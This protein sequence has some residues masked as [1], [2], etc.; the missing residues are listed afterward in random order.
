M[1]GY[2]DVFRIRLVRRCPAIIRV[3]GR[4]FHT[5]T[6]K[7]EKPFDYGFASC[8]DAVAKALLNDIQG[9]RFAYCQSDEVSLLLIDYNKLNSDQWFDG[10]VQKMASISAGIASVQFSFSFGKDGVF[11]S[12]V[13]SIPERDVLNYFIWRQQDATRNSIQMAARTVYSHKELHEKNTEEMQEMMFNKGINWNG[14]SP[15]F[16]RGRVIRRGEE[17]GFVVDS[18]IPIFTENRK[19]LEDFMSIE[20][21]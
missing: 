12:R 5:L 7:I 10:D 16:K 14:Y 2:D 15:Y 20:Q 1:N 21:E 8:I 9:S 19:Y 6:R 13:F 3:D 11:D 18:V 17:N 4:A